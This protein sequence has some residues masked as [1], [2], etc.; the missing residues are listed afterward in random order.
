MEW[1]NIANFKS[2]IQL[3]SRLGIYSR[4]MLRKTKWKKRIFYVTAS[5]LR[6]V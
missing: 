4:L 2:A 5:Y 6:N 3:E 1:K